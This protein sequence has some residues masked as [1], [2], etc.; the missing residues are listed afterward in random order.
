MI[1]ASMF[2]NFKNM[3]IVVVLSL[4]SCGLSAST[5]Q[6][7]KKHCHRLISDPVKTGLFYC[8]IV[9]EGAGTV[10]GGHMVW[11]EFWHLID[12]LRDERI[13][14]DKNQL[15]GQLKQVLIVGGLGLITYKCLK[16]FIHDVKK[17]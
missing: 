9:I 14:C 8:K 17:L 3:M 1:E 10:V 6:D 16:N 13:K 5:W 2:F 4:L 7:L 15:H 11:E 12:K